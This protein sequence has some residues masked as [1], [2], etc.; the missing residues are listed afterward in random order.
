MLRPGLKWKASPDPSGGIARREVFGEAVKIVALVNCVSLNYTAKPR[1]E[2][3]PNGRTPLPL[4]GWSLDANPKPGR[5]L[6]TDSTV[7]ANLTPNADRKPALPRSGN[8]ARLAT[9]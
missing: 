7:I 4:R 2:P 3:L 5:Y 1:G 9:G 6:A 8:P